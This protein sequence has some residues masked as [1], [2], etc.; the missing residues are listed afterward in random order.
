[1]VGVPTTVHPFSARPAGRTP[2]VIVHAY[3]C[4]PPVIPI[5]WLY[6]TPT[7][8]FG[9]LVNVSVTAPFAVIVR[10]TGPVTRCC[11]FDASDTWITMFAVPGVVGVPL[12]VQPVSVN[13]AGRVPV[14]TVQ[15][16]GAVPPVTP[17]VELYGT[18]TEPLG[19]LANVS[20]RSPGDVIVTLR[21]PVT[22]SFGFD[23]SVTCSVMVTVP[24]V[25][26]VPLIVQ[27]V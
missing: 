14:R 25:V 2:D 12:T 24:T 20:V 26:G 23:E 11:G 6:G 15:A 16:Y 19:R 17:I 18:P 13:P 9:R 22:L 1:M 7:V 10:L 27:P 3:G 4:V 21:E 8:P 5:G